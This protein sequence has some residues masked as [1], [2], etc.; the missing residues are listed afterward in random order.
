VLIFFEILQLPRG[1]VPF[2]NGMRPR[3]FA[4]L[5]LNS[6][7]LLPRQRLRSQT[8]DA[9]GLELKRRLLQSVAALDPEPKDLDQALERLVNEGNAPSGSLRALALS[10]RDE[11]QALPANPEW[12]EY[13]QSESA[14][15]KERGNGRG[16]DLHS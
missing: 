12:I 6:G 3:D 7:E 8:P 2:F 10:F 15:Q 11:W 5:L 4:L 14:R 16:L 1:T 9:L 13:L